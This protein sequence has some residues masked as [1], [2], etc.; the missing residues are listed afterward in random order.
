MCFENVAKCLISGNGH[1]EITVIEFGELL[2]PFSVKS[3]FPL[4]LA[5]N[6]KIKNAEL[7]FCL[8][9]YADGRGR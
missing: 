3:F 1:E 4:F 6:V 9:F 5:K 2:L 8:L 7:Q